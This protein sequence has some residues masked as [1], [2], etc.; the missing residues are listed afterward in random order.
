MPFPV[1]RHVMTV[2]SD[3]G[4]V[5]KRRDVATLLVF[6]LALAAVA[7]ITFMGARFHPLATFATEYGNLAENLALGHGFSGAFEVSRQPSAWMPPLLPGVMAIVFAFFGVK[8]Y[9]SARVLLG[10]QVVLLWLGLALLMRTAARFSPRGWLL[11]LPY[12][13]YIFVN[14]KLLF[15]D[16]HDIGLSILLSALALHSLVSLRER[17]AQPM[18]CGALLPLANPALGLAYAA[19]AP[20]SG[21]GRRRVLAVWAC[22]L[23]SVTCWSARNAVAL[24]AFVPLK[25][26]FW[27]DFHQANVLDPDGVVGDSTFFRFHPALGIDPSVRGD[28]RGGEMAFMAERKR[29]ALERLRQ[30]PGQYLVRV[31]NRLRNAAL[32]LAPEQETVAASLILPADLQAK[33]VKRHLMMGSLGGVVWCCLDQPAEGIKQELAEI[34]PERSDQLYDDWRRARTVLR[35]RNRAAGMIAWGLAEA[36]LPALVL[37]YGLWRP[38]LRNR[39]DFRM[40][41]G[42]YVV[43]LVPYVLASHYVRYQIA[44]LGL[45]AYL[46]WLVFCCGSA[47]AESGLRQLDAK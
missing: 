31:L 30:E 21:A 46:V 1:E 40:G 42:L 7:V 20:F 2:E 3:P 25:S 19:L 9:A 29:L 35:K 5:W 10:L 34:D 37:L 14:R 12:G 8:T 38:W 43:S 16:F 17:R 15:E 11:A 27:F 28:Y 33:L 44:M 26:N 45:T 24:G 22:C 18:I 23:V 47:V 13:A 36:L 32:L 4:G 6:G 41:G 39:A